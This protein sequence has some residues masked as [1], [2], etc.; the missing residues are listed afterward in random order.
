MLLTLLRWRM[1]IVFHAVGSMVIGNAV[2]AAAAAA[3]AATADAVAVAVVDVL[4]GELLNGLL[5]RIGLPMAGG[6][7]GLSG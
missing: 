2:A 7:D 3:D 6:G 4:K 1:F 5:D